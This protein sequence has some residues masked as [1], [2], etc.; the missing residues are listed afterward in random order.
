MERE[1]EHAEEKQYRWEEGITRRREGKEIEEERWG[2]TGATPLEATGTTNTRSAEF[3]Q[4][5][6]H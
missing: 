3:Y 2:T 6:V 1:R 5:K 4:V